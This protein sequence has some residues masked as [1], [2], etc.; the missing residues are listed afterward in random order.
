VPVPID[1]IAMLL[2]IE[3]ITVGVPCPSV[4]E[5]LATFVMTTTR[6]V[7]LVQAGIR[8]VVMWNEAAATAK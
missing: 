6:R 8:M 4:I 3:P 2:L 5:M 1:L 7:A